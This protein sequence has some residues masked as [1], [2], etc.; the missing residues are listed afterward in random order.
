MASAAA[1]LPTLASRCSGSGASSSSISDQASSKLFLANSPA[2]RPAAM[3]TGANRIRDMEHRYPEWPIDSPAPESSARL[4]NGGAR[5][6]AA[7]EHRDRP[8]HRGELEQPPDEPSP[9]DE[10]DGGLTGLKR[11]RA[12]KERREPDRVDELALREVDH[13]RAARVGGTAREACLEAL[14]SLHVKGAMKRHDPD[15]VGDLLVD[16]E[17][18]RAPFG[19]RAPQSESSTRS[20]TWLS[21]GRSPAPVGADSILS[22]ESIPSLTQPKTVCFPSSH[23]AASVVTMKNWEP[24]VLGPAL[25]IARAPRTTLWSLISSSNV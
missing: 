18:V 6:L 14:G 20:M 1:S 4:E 15:L 2:T 7:V 12:L 8:V 21:S 25:A 10:G 24:L 5:L 13:E 16:L 11:L 22:T 9:R 17:L 3:L 23:G 19:H